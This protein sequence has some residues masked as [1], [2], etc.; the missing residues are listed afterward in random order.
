M[1]GKE[2]SFWKNSPKPFI[3]Q[4][5][6]FFLF[7]NDELNSILPD[8]D[9][10]KNKILEEA[11]VLKCEFKSVVMEIITTLTVFKRNWV[12]RQLESDI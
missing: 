12:S 4:W 1:D 8:F 6:D 10:V 9:E 2:I 11:S 7:F 3:A 5:S